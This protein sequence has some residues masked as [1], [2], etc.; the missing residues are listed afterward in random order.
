MLVCRARVQSYWPPKVP[1][2]D[3]GF[4]RRILGDHGKL[5]MKV[6]R[7]TGSIIVAALFLRQR[8][9][10]AKQPAQFLPDTPNRPVRITTAWS[11]QIVTKLIYKRE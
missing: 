11:R 9:S 7:K 1:M 6:T 4:D 3:M 8:G 10:H 2:L 5:W